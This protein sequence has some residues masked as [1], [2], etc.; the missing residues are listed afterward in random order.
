MSSIPVE[1]IN[2]SFFDGYYKDI[3]RALIPDALT[4]AE[5][6][7]LVNEAGLKPGSKVLDL[8][9]GYGRHALSLA[10][11]G[12]N[13]TAVDNLADY[14]RE[15]REVVETEDLPVTALNEDVIQFQTNDKYDLIICMGNS[16]SFFNREDSEKLFS[17][18][19]KNLNKNGKFI[20]SS[21]MIA[22]IFTLHA[23]RQNQYLSH[24]MEVLK[25]REALI[26]F[27]L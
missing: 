17:G 4:K 19:S 7:Y 25:K 3:W 8:M 21:W 1:N 9:C 5:V 26:T 6:D 16:V 24:P 10:R 15:I 2:N 14:I 18:I 13:V 27:T 23:L 20:F 12:I 11:L 22:E